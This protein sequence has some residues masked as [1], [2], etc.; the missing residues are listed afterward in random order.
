[1]V[2]KVIMRGRSASQMQ[3]QGNQSQT[4]VNQVEEDSLDEEEEEDSNSSGI[5]DSPCGQTRNNSQPS[6]V[7]NANWSCV[8]N[9][10]P[11]PAAPTSQ[12]SVVH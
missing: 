8:N 4:Q 6:G 9:K 7:T 11:A 2:W 10:T 3:R 5:D 12:G 1:M